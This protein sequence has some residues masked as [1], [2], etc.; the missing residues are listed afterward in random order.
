MKQFRLISVIISFVFLSCN[1]SSIPDVSNIK[2]DLTSQRF[3]NDFFAMDTTAILRSDSLLAKKYPEFARAFNQNILGIRSSATQDYTTAV[4]TFIRDYLPMKDTASII[5]ANIDKEVAQIKHGLQFVKYYFPDYKVPT[6][7]ITFIGPI[8]A[9]FQTSFGV[10][11]DIKS[12]DIFGIGLQLH[13]GANASY[14]QNALG[15][16][17]YPLFISRNFDR[18]HIAV[19]CL[20]LIVDELY[21]E[22]PASKPLLEQMVEKGKRLYILDKFLPETPEYLKIN[23][24]KKQL[25]DCY[26]K[27]AVIWD[28]FLNNELLNNAEQNLTKN[29]IGESPKT[30]ELGE[31]AP[32]NIGSFAGWQI[33]KKYMSRNSKTSLQ[34][35]MKMDPREVYAESKYKP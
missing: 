13:L 10:Q 17:L 3:E 23:Y 27:E 16:E 26:S 8:D 21:P 15:Q 14:Y 6:K 24:T 11:G 5:Y 4:S 18:D 31:N 25:E 12:G 19:N 22:S 20:K 1:N 29:Y 35:L 2:L 30:Q 32:G 9:F 7:V 33:V 34:E 28:F